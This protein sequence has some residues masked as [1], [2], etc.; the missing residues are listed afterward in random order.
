MKTEV[1]IHESIKG[2]WLSKKKYSIF[3]LGMEYFEATLILEQTIDA[4]STIIP[5][6]MKPLNQ[7]S[8]ISGFKGAQVSSKDRRIM[9][10]ECLY[11]EGVLSNDR[12]YKDDSEL[13][14]IPFKV[15]ACTTFM[16]FDEENNEFIYKFSYDTKSEL[17]YLLTKFS[18][19]ALIRNPLTKINCFQVYLER[20][21][22]EGLVANWSKIPS[23]VES[24]YI[25]Y[26]DN[27]FKVLSILDNYQK[28]K[29][30][31]IFEILTN[32]L[33]ENLKFSKY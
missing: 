19:P 32:K 10:D 31:S 20:L 11:I 30:Q 5:S 26:S 24:I 17:N 21:S 16:N 22:L 25:D 7:V 15:R 14:K 1:K 33:R 28:A 27:R 9:K 8:D 18:L 29:S 4:L 3:E 13:E 12:T 6:F 2:F 23:S